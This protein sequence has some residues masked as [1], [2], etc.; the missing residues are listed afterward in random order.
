[1]IL[2][3]AQSEFDQRAR[4]GSGLRLPSMIGLIALHSGL[5]GAIPSAG[6]FTLQVVLADQCGLNF[7]GARRIDCLLAALPR[8]LFTAGRLTLLS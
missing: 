6:W 5:R 7:A 8:N 2:T 3:G 4:V 1:M